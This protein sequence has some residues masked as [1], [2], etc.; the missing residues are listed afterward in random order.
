MVGTVLF[1]MSWY[2][3]PLPGTT[4]AEFILA[5]VAGQRDGVLASAIVQ[6]ACAVVVVPS[7]LLVA[8]IREGRGSTAMYLG[9]V[10]LLIGAVGNGADAVYH[11]M[12]YEMTGPGVDVAAMTLVM[13]RMQTE[14]VLL[15][16]PLMIAFFVG[17]FVSA[18]GLARARLASPRLWQ[19][20][21][22]VPLAAVAGRIAVVTADVDAR[23]VALGVL[24]LFSAALG[25]MGWALRK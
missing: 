2:L 20:L 25:W 3:M 1:W 19:L 12:A 24:A 15:L 4:D 21:A 11:Q 14:D 5:A 17:A 18:V 8:R 10:L 13:E 7:A 6:T 9:A 23:A 22:L 16:A